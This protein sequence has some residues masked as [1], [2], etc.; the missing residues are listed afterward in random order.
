[1]TEQLSKADR[2]PA[3]VDVG[4]FVEIEFI[5]SGGERESLS[6]QLVV[7]AQADFKNGYLGEGT[8]LAQA[9]LGHPAGDTVPYQADE[10]E[11]VEIL[12]VQPGRA[13]Q[14][15]DVAARRQET[16]RKAAEQSDLTSTILF[17]S[18]FS[19]K[20]G[21]YDP[22]SLMDQWEQGKKDEDE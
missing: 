10:I 22:T 6:F 16:L 3:V 9:I 17:A 2:R 4:A 15:E 7:D 14:G 11:A 8:P 20:W 21:D 13:A 12:S 1:M 19:G 5:T 18:S